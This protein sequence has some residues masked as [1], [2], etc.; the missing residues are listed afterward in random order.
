MYGWYWT[1]DWP[2][3]P[4]WFHQ[5]RECCILRSE[6]LLGLVVFVFSFL[7]ANSRWALACLPS[8]YRHIAQMVFSPACTLVLWSSARVAVR[9]TFLPFLTLFYCLEGLVSSQKD[10]D[11]YSVFLLCPNKFAKQNCLATSQETGLYWCR[12][13]VTVG[14][15][16]Y[17]NAQRNRHKLLWTHPLPKPQQSA[18]GRSQT[19]LLCFSATVASHHWYNPLNNHL[20]FCY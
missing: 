15:C 19:P 17:I 12:M 9:P 6:S 8:G 4:S 20:V 13:L 16:R 7:F 11:A 1:C 10:L 14:H 5:T 3:L 18:K 2:I